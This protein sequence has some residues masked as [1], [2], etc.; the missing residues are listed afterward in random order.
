MN[1]NNFIFAR[2]TK[3]TAFVA[4]I[5]TTI[6][7]SA[8]ATNAKFGV[9]NP[10][11]LSYIDSANRADCKVFFE[12]G[13]DNLN[14]E[15]KRAIAQDYLTIW[16]GECKDGYANGLGAEISIY[17]DV[18]IAVYED[19]IPHY[20][21]EKRHETSG[22]FIGEFGNIYDSKQFDARN[23]LTIIHKKIF[24]E[25]ETYTVALRF[26]APQDEW[27]KATKD[28]QNELAKKS[29]LNALKSYKKSLATLQ[30]YKDKICNTDCTTKNGCIYYY[31]EENAFGGEDFDYFSLCNNETKIDFSDKV[32][33]LEAHLSKQETELVSKIK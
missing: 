23:G 33:E 6:M 10:R 32:S 18:Y 8:C 21:Y 28:A 16:D 19:K 3:I 14:D 31:I 4:T 26:F 17:G 27:Q 22:F 5:A 12:Y 29:A 25:G 9:E 24:G 20:I 13:D 7:F 15:K 30:E 2:F 1:T 11:E